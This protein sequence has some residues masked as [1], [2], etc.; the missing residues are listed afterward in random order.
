[1]RTCVR[2]LLLIALAISMTGCRAL[3]VQTMSI[4]TTVAIAPV[5]HEGSKR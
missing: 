3:Q 4:S 1:M 5:F 2:T